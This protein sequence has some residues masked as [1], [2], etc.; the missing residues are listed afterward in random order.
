MSIVTHNHSLRLLQ[1]S[2]QD[3][4]QDYFFPL[5]LKFLHHA[6]FKYYVIFTVKEWFVVIN[7]VGFFLKETLGRLMFQDPVFPKGHHLAGYHY[8]GEH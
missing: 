7:H 1:I 4:W 5:I 8:S 2:L 6:F 3:F